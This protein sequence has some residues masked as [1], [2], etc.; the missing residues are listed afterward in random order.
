MG[1]LTI[2]LGLVRIQSFYSI[3]IYMMAGFLYE[4]RCQ[5]VFGLSQ[6]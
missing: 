5:L 6:S 3:G 4:L 1:T 2:T